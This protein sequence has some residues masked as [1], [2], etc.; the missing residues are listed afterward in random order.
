MPQAQTKNFPGFGIVYPGGGV[1][2][3][4]VVK[5]FTQAPK[6]IFNSD[7]SVSYETPPPTIHELFGGGFCYADGKPVSNREHLENISVPDMKERALVW[8]ETH[9]KA[10]SP[11]DIVIKEEGEKERPEPDYILSNQLPQQEDE[12]PD[13]IKESLMS[14][15]K[16]ISSLAKMVN[17][18]GKEIAELKKGPPIP[19]IK[20]GRKSQS[21]KMKAKWANPEYKAKMLKRIHGKGELDETDRHEVGEKE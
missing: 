8:F 5:T 14:I 13:Q 10:I 17:E 7:G 15:A 4:K 2:G 18:Q 3:I 20:L 12:Q 19:P 1:T 21:E 16:S 11:S 6:K 9:G